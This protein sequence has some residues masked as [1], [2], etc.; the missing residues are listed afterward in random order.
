MSNELV[1]PSDLLAGLTQATQ[2]LQNA[3]GGGGLLL[4]LLKSG[5]WVYGPD[6]IDMEEGSEWAA[7][8]ATIHQGFICWGEGE[9]LGEE[10]APL[11]APPINKQS[12]E[13]LGK[14]WKQ[15]IAI[16]FRCMSG[17]DTGTT[18]V[19]KVTS[20][21]GLRAVDKLLRAVVTRIQAGETEVIPVMELG[22][23]SY[24]H[25][26]YG[27]IYT[28]VLEPTAWLGAPTPAPVDPEPAKEEA[29]DPPFEPDPK[30][31]PEKEAPKARR[32]K[33]A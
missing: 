6:D 2:A 21:G 25:K 31:E 4:R 11:N 3:T 16:E 30:S 20:V 15:Q 18:V 19:Y 29:T 23:D 7:N 9:I 33:R 12:L 1:N 26:E 5:D 13:S 17:E 32:R 22:V 24:K 10:M 27:R 14:P 28:P 8:P